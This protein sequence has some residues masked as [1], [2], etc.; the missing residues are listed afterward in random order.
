MARQKGIIKVVG[1]LD[2]INFYTRLGEP[3]MR[4]A[5]GGFTSEAIKTKES[6]VRV[7]EN[8][9]EFKYCMAA[10]KQFKMSLQPF[11]HQF[12]DTLLHQRLVQLFTQIKV[13]DT[14]SVRGERTVGNGLQSEAGKA[15][16]RG[17][18][19]TSG[20]NL[21]TV[22]RQGFLAEWEANG[23]RIPTFDLAMVR[24]PKGATHV[25][26]EACY[27][28]YDF[29]SHTYM[30]EKSMPEVFSKKDEATPLTLGVNTLPNVEG[31]KIMVVHL[32]FLQAV[33]GSMYPMKEVTSRVFEVVYVG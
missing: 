7:R 22:L 17:Y 1:T 20:N 15:L 18:V 4:M 24:F 3:L 13:F 16:L 5:G 19:L 33:N 6:M 31:T 10:V 8:G 21:A 12:K 2:G 29:T 25:S 32:C 27:L 14:V 30:L 11:I 23:F 9:N 26:L 28:I